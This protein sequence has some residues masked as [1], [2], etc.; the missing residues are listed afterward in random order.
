[1]TLHIYGREL[2]QAHVFAP[3]GDGWYERT[4]RTLGY[5]D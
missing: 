2:R 5:S 3:L 1:V 4:V